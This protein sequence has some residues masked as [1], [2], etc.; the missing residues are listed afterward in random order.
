MEHNACVGKMKPTSAVMTVVAHYMERIVLGRQNHLCKRGLSIWIA[1]PSQECNDG[2]RCLPAK[3]KAL[4]SRTWKSWLG[5]EAPRAQ[6]MV[7][8]GQYLDPPKNL[9]CRQQH[10]FTKVKTAT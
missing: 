8:S 4:R 1:A 2:D 6:A 9:S 5:Y 10:P 3:Q 7:E